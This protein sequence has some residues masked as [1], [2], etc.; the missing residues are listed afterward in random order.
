MEEVKLIDSL[1]EKKKPEKNV[2]GLESVENLVDKAI[3][4]SKAVVERL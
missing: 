2:H 4:D 3:Q 1:H